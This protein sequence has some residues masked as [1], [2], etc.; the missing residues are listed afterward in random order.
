MYNQNK[1]T[2]AG[3]IGKITEL[4]NGAVSLNIAVNRSYKDDKG[5]WIE[6]IKWVTIT[7]FEK[8]AIRIKENLK[9]GLPVVA[10]GTI[11]N[12]EYPN[13]DGEITYSV[14]LIVTKFS[15]QG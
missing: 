14:S 4:G 2:I 13:A 9:I 5:E 7:A 15:K 3:N 8:I 1:F 6:R 12:T 10:E 11:E